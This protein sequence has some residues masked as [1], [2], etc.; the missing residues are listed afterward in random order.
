MYAYP[1]LFSGNA[2]KEQVDEASKWHL[3]G[4]LEK[5]LTSSESNKAA[6]VAA[7]KSIL[8]PKELEKYVQVFKSRGMEGPLSWYRTRRVNWEEDRGK[9]RQA[10]L[11]LLYL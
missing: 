1:G 8:D 9:H 5:L 4:N 2:T 6:L 7:T 10:D 3:E 11:V